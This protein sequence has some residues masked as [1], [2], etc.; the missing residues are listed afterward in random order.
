MIIDCISVYNNFGIEYDNH[1]RKYKIKQ[2]I[3][4]CQENVC[5]KI[6]KA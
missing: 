3:F 4:L 1:L 2:E 6:H 5:A